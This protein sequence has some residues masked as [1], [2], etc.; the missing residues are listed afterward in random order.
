[1]DKYGSGCAGS[2]FLNGTLDIHLEL[3]EALARLVGKES[4]LLY[5]TGFQANFGTISAMVG[6][7]EYVIADKEDHASIMDGCLLSM[8]TF[9]RYNHNDMA[10]LEKLPEKKSIRRSANLLSWT[11]CSACPGHRAAHG[12]GRAC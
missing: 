6:R 2:R 8:G 1:V 5:S 4:V 9:L 11:G 3:E 7:G 10:G 12:N